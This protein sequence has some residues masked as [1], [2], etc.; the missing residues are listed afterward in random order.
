MKR[1]RTTQSARLAL[2]V[3]CCAVLAGAAGLATGAQPAE[4]E[5]AQLEQRRF[6]A[7]QAGDIATLERLLS[8]D[9][10][11]THSSGKQETKQEFLG[12]IRSGSL[13]YKAVAPE[14]LAVRVYDA[15][16][17]VTGRCHFQVEVEGRMLDLQVRFTDVY[18]KRDGAWQLVAWQSTRLPEP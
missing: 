5:I 16:A 3:A 13:K 10:T 18:V 4:S 17:V 14:G 1:Q 11:Y 7:M 15:A 9:L 2:V 12:G 8:P 6:A